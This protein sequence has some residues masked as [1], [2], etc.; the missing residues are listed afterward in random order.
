MN[1]RIKYLSQGAQLGGVC[2]HRQEITRV[3]PERGDGKGK[4]VMHVRDFP[5]V[6]RASLVSDAVHGIKQIPEAKG[7]G[8]EAFWSIA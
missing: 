2:K 8:S 1:W 3:E 5:S 6:Q 7:E 4:E